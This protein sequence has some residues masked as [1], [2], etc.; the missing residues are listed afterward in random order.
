MEQLE[1]KCAPS[2][3]VRDPRLGFVTIS[4]ADLGTGLRVTV[5]TAMDKTAFDDDGWQEVL[6][7]RDLSWLQ[8]ERNSEGDVEAVHVDIF[9]K[10]CF[11]LTESDIVDSVCEAV[12]A[13]NDPGQDQ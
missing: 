13:I 7:K 4:P 8:V 2:R 10:K 5:R 12:L 1:A 3:F 6:A 9:N 11:N